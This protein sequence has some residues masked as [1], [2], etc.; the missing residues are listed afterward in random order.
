[1]LDDAT[2]AGRT[3]QLGGPQVYTFRE[4]ME[5]TLEVT[6]RRRLLLPVPFWLA[7]LLATFLELL[8]SPPLTRDQVRLL[9]RDNVVPAGAPGLADFGIPPTAVELIVPTYLDVYRKG[10]RLARA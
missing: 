9:Q 2:T 6:N 3:Y 8:P 5:L 7:S 1:M 4:L 10:G